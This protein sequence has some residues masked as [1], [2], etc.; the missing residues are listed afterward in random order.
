MGNKAKSKKRGLSQRKKERTFQCLLRSAEEV[1][2]EH[3]F[4]RASVSGICQRAGVARGTFYLYFANK[5][6]V[7]VRLVEELEV[8]LL[9]RLRAV[10]RT[11]SEPRTKLARTYSELLDVLT[12]NQKLFQVFREAEFVRQE[13]AQR[14]YE[15]VCKILTD[16]VQDGMQ[17]V[18]FRDLDPDVVA[19]AILG[20]AL[21]QIVYY[22]LWSKRTVPIE[23]SQAAIELVLRGL[24]PRVRE[25]RER[26]PDRISLCT[27]RGERRAEDL[28]GGEATRQAIL[29]AAEQAFGQAGFNATP[30]ST[31]TYLAGVGLGT[32]YL[33]FPSKLA[34]FEELV[35]KISRDLRHGLTLTVATFRDRRTVEAVGLKAFFLWVQRHSG[36]YRILRE[37]E[38]VDQRLGKRHYTRLVERY[39]ERLRSAMVHDEIR[40]TD[41]E[42]LACALVGIAH[43]GG[44]RWVLWERE[45]KTREK[46]AEELVQLLIHGLEIT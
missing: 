45:A 17:K 12:E 1:F 10:V 6:D 9:K 46:A 36:A 23:A 31:I 2:S 30:V 21:F 11:D 28:E 7:Y 38:F 34:L 43:L 5:E 20:A 42:G 3:G 40:C 13:I 18:V 41:P 33:Y 4:E 25:W 19:Y 37:A 22:V 27:F 24:D 44:Q 14:F 26:V 29:D 35:Q 39:A 15:S 8:K 16:V 32:F